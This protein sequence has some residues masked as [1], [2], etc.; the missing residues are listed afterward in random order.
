[1]VTDYA[2]KKKKK[3]KKRNGGKKSKVDPKDIYN[4][5]KEPDHWK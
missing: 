2:K 1:M 3:K 4:Y 5:S